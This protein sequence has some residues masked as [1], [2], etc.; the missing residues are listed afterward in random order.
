M[1][2]KLK[3]GQKRQKK[4]KNTKICLGMVFMAKYQKKSPFD[5]N[6]LFWPKSSQNASI[7]EMFAWKRQIR[8]NSAKT[9]SRLKNVKKLQ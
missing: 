3:Y 2:K 4:P 6:K 5:K 9:E 1:H 8:W 7:F